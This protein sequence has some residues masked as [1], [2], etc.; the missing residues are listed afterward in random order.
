MPLLGPRQS[1]G[2]WIFP[3]P[4][5]EQPGSGD[6]A[7]NMRYRAPAWP[8]FSSSV[9]FLP[10]GLDFHNR[11]YMIPHALPLSLTPGTSAG[12]LVRQD[13]PLLSPKH[14][15]PLVASLSHVPS[16]SLPPTPHLQPPPSCCSDNQ[17]HGTSS[18][19]CLEYHLPVFRTHYDPSGS[20]LGSSGETPR[21]H[22]QTY[23]TGLE[24]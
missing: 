18:F 2:S 20:V 15:S 23:E 11:L 22:F 14:R 10:S 17:M 16:S 8:A 3:T 12:A 24:L 5:G 6:S 9:F 1:F 21:H 19:M 4:F 13:N 7:P